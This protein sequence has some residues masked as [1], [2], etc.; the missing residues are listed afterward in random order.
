MQCQGKVIS[1]CVLLAVYSATA[2]GQQS[3]NSDLK[4]F[5]RKPKMFIVNGYSTS[6]QWPKVLQR[7]LDKYFDDKRVIE[8]KSATKGGTP[9]AKWMDINTGKPLPPW[10]QKLS[11]L[12]KDKKQPIVVL[13]QQSLQW[14]F[15]SRRDGIQN[16]RDAKNIQTGAVAIKRYTDLLLSEGADIVVVAM[17][18]YKRGME[19]EIGNERLALAEFLKSQ[20]A[21]VY[22]GPDVWEPTKKL[23][24][25]AF[26]ED[27]VHP[28]EVG[29]EIMAH[30]W[31]LTLL[32]LDG[33]KIPSWSEEEMKQAI[34]NLP[35]ETAS[36][37][38][39]QRNNNRRQEIAERVLGDDKNKDGKVTKDEFR[40]SP[41]LFERLDRN[42]D[43]VISEKDFERRKKQQ[44]QRPFNVPD[45]V[46]IL[47]DVKYGTGGERTLTMDIV[48][49]KHHGDKLLPVY[50][51]IHGGGWSKGTKEGGLLRLIR[52]ARLGFVGATIEYRLSG[53]KVFPAQIEDCKCAI[54]FLRAHAK[55][56]Q[57]DPDHI[58]VG[59]SS[60]GGHL[61]ALLG[62]SGDTKE[63]EGTGGWQK[64][65]SSVQAVVDFYGPTDLVQFAKTPGYESHAKPS[66]PESRLLGGDVLKQ[67][68]RAIRANPITYIDANDPPFLIIHGSDD[69]AVPPNQS[70]LLHEALKKAGVPNKLYI[71]KGAGHG[72]RGFSERNILEMEAS[73][74]MKNLQPDKKAKKSQ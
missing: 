38:R 65:S 68:D 44:R 10:T 42:S 63:L 40:G 28:N 54:R 43:G 74:L 70:E 2:S 72:G 14:V 15:G 4:L 5:D 60:A 16:V 11:P 31:F 52:C 37:K 30:Y 8:V 34:A 29:A 6:F 45:D 71:I 26:Q 57:I 48:R 64:Q 27:S 53:E 66:S 21:N 35:N 18:I 22:P 51:W 59:G 25:H 36:K 69:R 62:T 9:I 20:P 73:F 19:P 13:S 24:P 56:Y 55:K 33:R 46:E 67:V 58:A 17:H 32:K 39:R 7:K 50:V 49:P 61:A 1:V 47:R 3:S 23:W 12:L 41:R